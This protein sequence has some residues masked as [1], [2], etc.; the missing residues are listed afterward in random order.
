M[1]V[2]FLLLVVHTYMNFLLQDTLSTFVQTQYNIVNLR[3]LDWKKMMAS[4]LELQ[5]NFFLL[6]LILVFEANSAT[7]FHKW[8][9]FHI[10]ERTALYNADSCGIYYHYYLRSKDYG[11]RND[12]SIVVIQ[13]FTM[14]V[15]LYSILWGF[16]YMIYIF[17]C[18]FI[19]TVLYKYSLNEIRHTKQ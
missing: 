15:K 6:T 5:S 11:C 7:S 3:Q 14:H 16:F 9:F 19:L 13:I 1:V 10:L 18:H 4:K 12:N 2:Y 17:R 8:H